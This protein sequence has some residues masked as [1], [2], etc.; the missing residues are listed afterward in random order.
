MPSGLTPMAARLALALGLGVAYAP[1][2]AR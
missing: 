1:S 2:I